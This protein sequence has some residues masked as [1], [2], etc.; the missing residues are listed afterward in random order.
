M[1][2]GIRVTTA[3]QD[4]LLLQAAEQRRELSDKALARRLGLTPR[5]VAMRLYRLRQAR[6]RQRPQALPAS[7]DG[8]GRYREQ[9]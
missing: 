2:S 1:T 4:K 5:Q 9:V 8:A 3:E 6:L 7:R